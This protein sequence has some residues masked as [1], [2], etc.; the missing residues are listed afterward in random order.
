MRS[1]RVHPTAAR[2]AFSRAGAGAGA[3]ISPRTDGS[4]RKRLR[5]L[6]HV[7][8]TVLELPCRSDAD[9]AV[10][11]F[12]G[13]FRFI[14]DVG[15]FGSEQVRARAMEVIP[16]L[17]KIVVRDYDE[18]DDDDSEQ[19]LMDKLE[20]DA[21]RFRFPSSTRPE[22]VAAEFVGGLLVVTVPKGWELG[23]EGDAW[24]SP[25]LVLVR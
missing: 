4:A 16:G 13:Y 20:M 23:N 25:G 24:H 11:E 6:P 17:I 19:L 8:R 12:P 7:F 1:K 10:Q 2:R 18:N 22:M 9:V 15:D 3:P 21:W 5:R 14:A